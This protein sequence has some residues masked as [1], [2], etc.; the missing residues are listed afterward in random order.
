MWEFHACGRDKRGDGATS[1]LAKLAV[2][3]EKKKKAESLHSIPYTQR[4]PHGTKVLNK[5]IEV[6]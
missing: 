6:L 1:V 2:H 5:N 3:F 4:L